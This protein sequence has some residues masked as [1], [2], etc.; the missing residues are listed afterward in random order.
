MYPDRVIY[1]I[2]CT[3]PRGEKGTVFHG[4]FTTNLLFLFFIFF[5]VPRVIFYSPDTVRRS[6]Y[7]QSR[8]NKTRPFIYI[9]HCRTCNNKVGVRIIC[10]MLILRKTEV[11]ICTPWQYVLLIYFDWHVFII[12]WEKTLFT[13]R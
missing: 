12:V 6:K 3:S 1:N 13:T 5:N 9:I 7:V 4:F 10:S 8:C 11:Y 2:Q